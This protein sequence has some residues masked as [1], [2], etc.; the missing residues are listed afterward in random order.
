MTRIEAIRLALDIL[1]PLSKTG[2]VY[3][4]LKIEQGF[5]DHH[6]EAMLGVLHADDPRSKEGPWSVFYESEASVHRIGPFDS[7]DDAMQAAINAQAE[8]EYDAREQ[9][10]YLVGPDHRMLVLSDEDVDGDDEEF[11]AELAADL[12][13]ERQELQDF[14]GLDP[15]E[16][17]DLGGDW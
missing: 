10:I 4:R 16:G 15:F 17:S 1:R 14:E 13:L 12:I 8:G 7:R 3:E 9:Q 5:S 2:G 6:Y 11:D